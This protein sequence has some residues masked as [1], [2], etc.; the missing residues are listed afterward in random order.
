LLNKQY[1]YKLIQLTDKF[2]FDFSQLK[3]FIAQNSNI[4]IISIFLQQICSVE[5]YFIFIDISISFV[6]QICNIFRDIILKKVF[7]IIDI[8]LF[9]T[10]SLQRN[11]DTK[12]SIKILIY[13]LKVDFFFLIYTKSI[14]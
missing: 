6:T 13:L 1:L 11:I 8:E 14:R 5:Y 12:N 2:D 4:K 9:Q 3:K 7:K 10:K